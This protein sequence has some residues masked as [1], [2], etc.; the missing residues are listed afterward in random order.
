M[1]EPIK[2]LIDLAYLNFN[3]ITKDKKKFEQCDI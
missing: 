3:Y 1:I 2:F